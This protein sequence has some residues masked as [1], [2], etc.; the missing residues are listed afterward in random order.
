MLSSVVEIGDASL[1]DVL[2]I[3]QI[4]R[5]VSS[6]S[7]TVFDLTEDETVPQNSD[8]I[9]IEETMVDLTAH[10]IPCPSEFDILPG[11]RCA[12]TRMLCPPQV[13]NRL[14]RLDSQRLY[15]LTQEFD[16]DEDRGISKTYSVMGASGNIFD[17]CICKKP[18]C[19][20]LEATENNAVMPCK[21]VI[22]I[23]VKVKASKY[24]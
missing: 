14:N 15:V 10:N 9:N 24:K 5:S 1:D 19:T 20:C 22:F 6:T 4:T 8:A 13:V 16:S 7:S 11:E 2:V 17:V 23:L 18:S 21:H 3:P 12:S